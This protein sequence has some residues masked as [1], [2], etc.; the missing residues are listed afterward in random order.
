MVLRRDFVEERLQALKQFAVGHPGGHSCWTLLIKCLAAFYIVYGFHCF[1]VTIEPK[2]C[3]DTADFCA[4][5]W[6]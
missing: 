2:N 6:P 1:C 3:V 5:Q 4:E